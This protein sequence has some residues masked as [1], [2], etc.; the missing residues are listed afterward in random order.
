M[1]DLKGI[2]DLVRSEDGVSRRLLLAYGAALAG[3]PLIASRSNAADRKIVF[4]NNP[5]TLG[6]ASGDPPPK[7]SSRQTRESFADR[8]SVV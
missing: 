7:R 2:P 3:L 4:E 1:F 8:K 6:V 5:F